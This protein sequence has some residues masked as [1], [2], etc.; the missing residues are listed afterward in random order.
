MAENRTADETAAVI[1]SSACIA[2]FGF[3]GRQPKGTKFPDECL[4]CSKMLDCMTAKTEEKVKTPPKK[5]LQKPR[6]KK[7]RIAT[8]KPK[9]KTTKPTAEM[10]E[11]PAETYKLPT[12]RPED[13]FVVATAGK[14]FERWS[15]TVLIN[16]A[17]VEQW[18][19]RWKEIE[20][21][22][23]TGRK[24]KCKVL[25]VQEVAEGMIHLPDR[26]RLNLG[27]GKGDVVKVK[28]IVR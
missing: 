6:P 8:A 15:N 24:A 19:K 1:S 16:R 26:L 17:T 10:D 4:T 20:I 27:I 7:K 28:L 2:Y 23:G 3:L 14:L 21:T 18:G 11:E 12:R 25:P 9:R 5:K 13:E 22:T